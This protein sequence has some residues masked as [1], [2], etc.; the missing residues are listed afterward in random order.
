[1]LWNSEYSCKNENSA[2]PPEHPVIKTHFHIF[3]PFTFVYISPAK[4]QQSFFQPRNFICL[5]WLSA[6]P[7][8]TLR[9]LYFSA[10]IKARGKAYLQQEKKIVFK[11]HITT[12]FCGVAAYMQTAGWEIKRWMKVCTNSREGL[13]RILL[14][15]FFTPF[16]TRLKIATK[17]YALLPSVKGC[18]YMCTC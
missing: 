2:I 16:T 5:A 1:M 14:I 4:Q 9:D 6:N 3:F 15:F 17:K 12:V 18:V 8:L 13:R 10:L 7:T 11:R